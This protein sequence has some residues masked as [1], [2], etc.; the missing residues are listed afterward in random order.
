MAR[1]TCPR[2]VRRVNAIWRA[3]V[4]IG[5]VLAAVLGFRGAAQVPEWIWYGNTPAQANAVVF[6]RR[7]FSV[8]FQAQRAELIAGGDDEVTVYLNGVE[9]G[10]S[11]DWKKPLKLEVTGAL[12]E[13][14]GGRSFAQGREAFAAAQCAACHRMGNEGGS[15]GPDL[16]GVSGRFNRRDLL[17]NILVPSK[18]ILDRYRTFTV[19]RRDGEELSGTIMEETDEKIVLLV[20]PL[21]QQREDVL[22]KD[23][24]SR[25]VSELSQMP[26]GLLNVLTEGEV[27]DLLAYLEADGKPDHAAFAGAK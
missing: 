5:G 24:Q 19:T 23:I 16:T 4:S 20:N 18:V 8:G 2:T 15:V 22:K 9:A 26:E 21:T 1:M 13:S 27:L 17:E 12:R 3:L 6:F 10:H 7:Q 25:A 11:T 14:G